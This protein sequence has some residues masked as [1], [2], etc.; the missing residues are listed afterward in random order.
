MDRNGI[1]QNM[2]SFCVTVE[3]SVLLAAVDYSKHQIGRA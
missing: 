1:L 2:F 3:G